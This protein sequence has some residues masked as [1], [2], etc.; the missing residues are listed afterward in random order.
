MQNNPD[1]EYNDVGLIID[2]L[3]ST[4]IKE[5][6]EEIVRQRFIKILQT[7]YG[8]PKD[9]ILREVP[10]QS[11]SSILT[12]ESDGSPIRAD[13]VVYKDKRSA[14]KKDQGN[15]LFVVE[16]KKPNVK[17]GYNQLVSY[18]FNTSAVGGV[19]TNGEGISV[20]KKK[21][22]E[23]GLEEIL[24]LPRYRE[25]WQDED[26][27]PSKSSLPRPHNVRFLLSTCHNKLYGRG[28]ENEDFDLAMDM[29]RI[30]LARLT[31]QSPWQS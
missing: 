11:G 18:I 15:I 7:D 22:N 16:C 21:Q 4:P 2:C 1:I 20:Y 30:L 14:L 31:R 12:N 19:W 29:V 3:T 6:P 13:I 17:E 27:I 23:I 9:C 5:T 10:V 8:Y 24:S 28:M 25:N 26:A